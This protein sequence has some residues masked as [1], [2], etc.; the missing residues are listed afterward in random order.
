MGRRRVIVPFHA[1]ATLHPKT[2]KEVLEASEQESIK[3]IPSE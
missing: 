1:N 2:I 3:R